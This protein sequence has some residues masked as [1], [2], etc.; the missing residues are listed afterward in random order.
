VDGE[1]RAHREGMRNPSLLALVL[2][3]A[4]ILAAAPSIARAD[5]SGGGGAAAATATS[6][7]FSLEADPMPYILSGYDVVLGYQPSW[8]PRARVIASHHSITFPGA[9]LS[10]DWHGSLRGVTLHGQY[11]SRAGGRGWMTGIQIAYN[12][13][14]YTRDS[15]PGMTADRKQLEVA[16]F[17]GYRWFP[18]ERGLF[19]VGWLKVGLPVTVAGDEMLGDEKVAERKVSIYPSVH[20]G[21]E[22]EL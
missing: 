10:G 11:F 5:D 19:L 3:P 21:W 9:L 20:I 22:I 17:G 18:F 7:R 13:F 6:Q 12:D 8:A 1:L 14:D 4:A 15:V 2:V 16:A